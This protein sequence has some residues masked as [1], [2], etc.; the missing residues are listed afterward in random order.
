MINV[1][2]IKLP[3]SLNGYKNSDEES[4]EFLEPVS[5][6]NIFVGANNSGKSRFMRELSNQ[7]N[8]DVEIKDTNLLTIRNLII[9]Q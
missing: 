3:E 7:S 4:L 6:I 5:K 1:T 8:Y 2:A 9:K